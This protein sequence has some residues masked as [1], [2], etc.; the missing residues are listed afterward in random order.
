M[1]MKNVNLLKWLPALFF[2]GLGVATV[3]CKKDDPVEIKYAVNLPET[4]VEIDDVETYQLSPTSTMGGEALEENYTYSSSSE[5]VARVSE[6]GLVSA[7]GAGSAVITVTG[8][9]SNES[10]KLSLTVVGTPRYTKVYELDGSITYKWRK[11][12]V[13]AVSVYDADKEKELVEGDDMDYILTENFAEGW[14]NVK[15]EKNNAF[16]AGGVV[17]FLLTVSDNEDGEEIQ[18]TMHKPIEFEATTSSITFKWDIKTVES[19]VVPA[20]LKVYDRLDP[21]AEGEPYRKGEPATEAVIGEVD[22]DTTVVA[23]GLVSRKSYYYEILDAEGAVIYETDNTIP[24]PITGIKAGNVESVWFGDASSA[25]NKYAECRRIADRISIGQG[26]TY[27][28]IQSVKVKDASGSVLAEL[29]AWAQNLTTYEYAWLDT[30]APYVVSTFSAAKDVKALYIHEKMDPA[31]GKNGEF[32]HISFF[33]LPY[34]EE[35]YIVEIEDKEGTVYEKDFKTKKKVAT[36]NRSEVRAN[37]VIYAS[38]SEINAKNLVFMANSNV[39]NDAFTFT[40]SDPAVA[41]V[42][43]SGKITFLENGVSQIKAESNQGAGSLSYDVVAAATY[44]NNY[45]KFNG[46]EV[47]DSTKM[48][49]WS[50]NGYEFASAASSNEAIAKVIEDKGDYFITAVAEGSAI[51]TITDNQG[52]TSKMTVTVVQ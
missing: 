24:S 40:S 18:E 17:W 25:G 28:Q 36:F 9:T 35:A 51:V 37:D 33:D 11:H 30:E 38:A 6:T 3:S 1:I 20:G 47:A 44:C 50:P 45:S 7:V 15:K 22:G 12:E 10:A 19:G 2:G 14:F 26:L 4:S 23:T 13:T 31:D 32:K 52:N 16:N 39:A 43:A 42:D 41:T 21:I 5:D 34:S 49:F 27:D 48:T 8:K 29:G 46:M